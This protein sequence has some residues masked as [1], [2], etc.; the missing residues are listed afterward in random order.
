MNI[1]ILL[2]SYT[3]LLKDFASFCETACGKYHIPVLLI[4]T[5][6]PAS[7]VVA[8]I[9]K[10]VI[11]TDPAP[12]GQSLISAIKNDTDRKTAEKKLK[13]LAGSSLYFTDKYSITAEELDALDIKDARLVF[14]DDFFK[15]PSPT[16]LEE[17]ACRKGI[18]VIV[19]KDA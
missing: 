16:V 9:L 5:R 11:L 13:A 7:E 12:T 14:I 6:R 15:V 4:S 1:T 2:Q 8:S 17:W 10:S 3:S 19:R 18:T